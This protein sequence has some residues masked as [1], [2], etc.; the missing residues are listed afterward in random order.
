M[1]PTIK[2]EKTALVTGADGGLGREI[3]RSLLDNGYSLIMACLSTE[4]AMPFY[5]Q[6]VSEYEDKTNA[7]FIELLPLDLSSYVS[8]KAFAE[9]ITHKSINRLIHNAGILPKRTCM[10]QDGLEK[11]SQV[12]YKAPLY[13]TELLL[14]KLRKGALTKCGARI[15]FTVS[16]TI[17]FGWFSRFK[18]SFVTRIPR[19]WAGRVIRYG[20]SKR[21]LYYASLDL[22]EKLH[23]YDIQVVSADPGA[24][25]TPMITMNNRLDPLVNLF[26]KPFLSTPAR[27]A[28]TTIYLATEATLPDPYGGTY[29]KSRLRRFLIGKNIH[30]R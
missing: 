29:R 16:C 25:N 21:A 17:Y 27:G 23:P 6:L 10:T 22:A 11:I 26:F 13:L 5:K 12:N 19:N 9:S 24:V 2:P 15:I 14:P 1:A 18:P 20:D 4:A 30:Y 8:V 3:C 28:S 7:S